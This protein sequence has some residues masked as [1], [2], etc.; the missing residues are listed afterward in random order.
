MLALILLLSIC[1]IFVLLILVLPLLLQ[2]TVITVIVDATVAAAVVA[3]TV[4]IYWRCRAAEP[5]N[6]R[7]RHQLGG[8]AA[9]CQEER[10]KLCV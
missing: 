1:L 4:R 10:S 2:V 5:A 8:R 7:H 3:C 6:Q 9:S